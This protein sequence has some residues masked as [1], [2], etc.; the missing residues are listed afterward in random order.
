MSASIKIKIIL[1]SFCLVL[2]T[3]LV[4]GFA[5]HKYTLIQQS[6]DS[7]IIFES[8]RE[9]WAIVGATLLFALAIGIIFALKI[10]EPV[11]ELIIGTQLIAQGRLDHRIKKRN[12]DEIGRLVDSFNNMIS[13]LRA[14]QKKSSE[15]SNIATVE[16]QKAELIIDSMADSVIVTNRQHRVELFNPAAERLFEMNATSA[17]GKHIVNFLKKYKLE[18]IFE[19]FPDISD[20]MLPDPKTH[21]RVREYKIQK[22]TKKILKITMAPLKNYSDVVIGTVTVIEDITKVREL[23]DMKTGFVSTVS[24]ELRTPLTSI[25]GYAAL[26]AD[27]RLGELSERQMKSINIIDKESDRL[28]DLIN[29]ILDLSKLESGKLK[30]NFAQVSLADCIKE[31]RLVS[32]AK[33]KGINIR[34]IIPKNTPLLWLDKTKI[35]Q[36]FNNLISNAIKFTKKGGRITIKVKNHREIVQV[37]I[38]D[39]G[40][41]IPKKEIPKLFNKFYQVESHLTRN[42]GGTGLGLPIVKEIIGLHHGLL[43]VCSKPK[44]GTTVSFSLPKNKPNENQDAKCW[45][46]RNCSKVNCP[47]YNSSDQRCWLYIGTHCKKKSNEPTLN[48]IDVCRYCDVYKEGL[49]NEKDS[50]SG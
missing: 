32:H 12:A 23:D 18:E 48:K 41:G 24:H 5:V 44:S 20:K 15:F 31:C 27:G 45:E 49:E 38:A 2:L 4:I 11:D 36:V 37:D 26:M 9:T 21:A 29:D 22:P 34:T 40:I 47:A 3:A 10:V 14:S 42:Q 46:V 17:I 33:Q 1:M 43:S 6:G 39:S 50:D 8:G 25:K 30:G 7:E 19:E 16:K 13:K 28:T 35:I